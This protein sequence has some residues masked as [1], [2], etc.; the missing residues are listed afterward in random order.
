MNNVTSSDEQDDLRQ[1][2]SSTAYRPL[3]S[4]TC[5]SCRACKEAKSRRGC[6]A[7]CYKCPDHVVI[8]GEDTLSFQVDGLTTTQYR[9]IE[10]DRRARSLAGEVGNGVEITQWGITAFKGRDWGWG[11]GGWGGLHRRANERTNE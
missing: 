9:R 7:A 8:G 2:G 5:E 3:P 11:V 4:K 1:L 6:R 10:P